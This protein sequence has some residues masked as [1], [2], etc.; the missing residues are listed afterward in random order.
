M[1]VWILADISRNVPG[2]MRRHMELHAEGLRRAGHE[3]T[4]IFSEDVVGFEPL[5]Q[6]RAPGLRSFLAL[7][8]RY[9]KERPDLVNVHAACA[10]GWIAA[11]RAGAVSA[12]IVVMSYAADEPHIG[13]RRPRDLLRLANAA[14]PARATFRDANGIWCVNQQ[15]AEYYVANYGIQRSRIGRFPHAVSD[16]FF[17]IDSDSTRPARLLFV[18]TWIVRKGMDVLTEALDRVVAALPHVEITLAG[19]LSG[20]ARVRSTLSA[21]V[22]RQTRVVD[23]ATDRE[24]AE[25]YATSTLL[26]LPSRYEGLPISMLEAMA[27]GCPTLAAANSGMLDVIENGRNGWL[28]PSFDPARWSERICYLLQRPDELA[29]AS[30]GAR[31]LAQAFRIDTVAKNVIEWYRSLPA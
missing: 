25:L 30:R 26:L 17:S 8:S 11:R 18:G 20:E 12:K 3:A 7:R 19:T 14:L 21:A 22:S 1:H 28:E 6:L 16:M 10:P 23:V 27:C 13:L 4:L 2:G 9:R 29:A 24:L 31:I 5:L 15:D